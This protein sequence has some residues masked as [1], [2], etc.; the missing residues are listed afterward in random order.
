MVHDIV[1]DP[2]PNS[3][4]RFVPTP[5]YRITHNFRFLESVPHAVFTIGVIPYVYTVIPVRY[6]SSVLTLLPHNVSHLCTTA[7]LDASLQE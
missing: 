6:P 4:F 7:L 1:P 3:P 5:C 2:S